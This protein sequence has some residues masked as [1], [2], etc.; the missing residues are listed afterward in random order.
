[1]SWAVKEGECLLI[2]SG[3]S[4]KHLFV[5]VRVVTQTKGKSQV[6]SCPVCSIGD[7]PKYDTACVL[8][9]G[10]HPFVTHPTFVDYRNARL[11]DSSH[12]ENMVRVLTFIPQSS[13]SPEML[14]RLQTGLRESMFVKRHLKSLI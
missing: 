6:I 14:L 5:I 2:D 8:Q 9:A 13:A 11:D 3:P 4:G 1:M 10:D 12:V 7:L